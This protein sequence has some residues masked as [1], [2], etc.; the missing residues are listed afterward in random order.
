[1]RGGLRAARPASFAALRQVRDRRGRDRAD[2]FRRGPGTQA[3]LIKGTLVPPL[4]LASVLSASAQVALNAAL[5]GR[6][7][8][9]VLLYDSMSRRD[10]AEK[11]AAGIPGFQARQ[12]SMGP[13]RRAR[14]A[15]SRG[16]STRPR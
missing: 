16:R 2:G 14:A 6:K 13:R 4:A 11:S 7:S 10:W 15:H 8:H 5:K 9:L 3:E 1:M 12:R